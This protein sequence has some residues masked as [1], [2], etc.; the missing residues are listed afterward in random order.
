MIAKNSVIAH[1]YYIRIVVDQTLITDMSYDEYNE[2]GVT[3]ENSSIRK[4]L[5]NDFYEAAFTDE[6]KAAIVESTLVN[7]I[8]DENDESYTVDKVF[9]LSLSEVEK[10]YGIGKDKHAYERV[11]CFDDDIISS[12]WLRAPSKKKDKFFQQ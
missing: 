9:L 7:K 1:I 10:Y 3:W 2:E 5:N 6:E 8:D 12:W 11:C 4:W